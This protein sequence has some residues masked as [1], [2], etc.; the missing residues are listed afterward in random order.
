LVLENIISN[1]EEKEDIEESSIEQL[2]DNSENSDNDLDLSSL[3][4]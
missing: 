1:E 2:S 4:L 3:S